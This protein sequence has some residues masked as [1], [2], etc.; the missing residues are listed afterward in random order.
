MYF[1]K[2]LTTL[3]FL[4]SIMIS[5]QNS[6]NDGNLNR[7]ENSTAKYLEINLASYEDLAMNAS[8]TTESQN[9]IYNSLEKPLEKYGLTGISYNTRR[10][11]NVNFMTFETVDNES[12]SENLDTTLSAFKKRR[13]GMERTGRILTFIGVPLGIIGGIMV[14][15]SD[16]LYYECVNGNCTGDARGGFGVVLLA[17]G[18]GLSGTGGVLWILGSKK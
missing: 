17:A 16:E 1:Q 3:L 14:A 7:F 11:A 6:N 2:T 5:A 12:F 9:F 8:L 10:N 18:V 15:G 13:S 4:V